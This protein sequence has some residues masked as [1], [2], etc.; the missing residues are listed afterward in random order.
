MD[1]TLIKPK[2]GRRFPIDKNDWQ[3]LKNVK[4]KLK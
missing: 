2:S 1:Y 4:D 3:F